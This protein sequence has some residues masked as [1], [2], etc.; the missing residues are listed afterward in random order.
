MALLTYTEVKGLSGLSLN[1]VNPDGFR[2]EYVSALR[3]IDT[4]GTNQFL[5]LIPNSNEVYEVYAVSLNAAGAVDTIALD[6]L[7]QTKLVERKSAGYCL[8]NPSSDETKR[9]FLQVP[10]RVSGASNETCE[11]DLVADG[12]VANIRAFVKLRVY[13]IQ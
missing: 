4:A 9:S 13:S 8:V 12:A 2:T 7:K 5:K 11:I 10:V 6:T 1:S 3:S